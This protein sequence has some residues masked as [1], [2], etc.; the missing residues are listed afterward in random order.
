MVDKAKHGGLR[1][2]LGKGHSLRRA[3]VLSPPAEPMLSENPA[4]ACIHRHDEV[5]SIPFYKICVAGM[6]RRVVSGSVQRGLS[7]IRL[8]GERLARVTCA[9]PDDG[10]TLLR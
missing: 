1:F 8:R 6:T 3:L 7:A 4:W 2:G 5:Q 10:K 9:W